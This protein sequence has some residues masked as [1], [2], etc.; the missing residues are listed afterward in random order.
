MKSI[1]KIKNI[2]REGIKGIWKHRSMG[3]AS[4]IST[5]TTLFVIGLILIITITVNNIAYEIQG[6][7]DE[8]EVFI[9]KDASKLDI[10]NL[11]TKIDSIDVEKKVTFRTGKDALDIMKKSWGEDAKLL[12]GITS[13]DL[14]PSS[15][16]V[17]LT[18]I[19][20][21]D[22]FAAQLKGEKAV[23]DI[24]Y[25]KDLIQKVYRISNYIKIFGTA[26]VIVLI[27]VSLFII[28]N[29]IKLTVVSRRDEISVMKYVGATDN[30]VRIPF[31]IEGL[32][33][34]V[35]GALL[36]YFAVYYLYYFAYT[37][38]G[39]AVVQNL[40]IFSLLGPEV[41][42]FSLIQIF[43]S[44]GIGIGVIGSIF[45]IRRYLKS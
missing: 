4:V 37:K 28:S 45:S 35:L 34:G 3:M 31:I 29:T 39:T 25:Y 19:S 41:F 8:V 22:G 24:K 16:V 23:D 30:Y 7:V 1:R 40:S 17:K 2:F 33:F 21:A 10:D 18:D 15:F 42:K 11:C 12:E 36:S 5:F 43:L 32:F 44:I 20:N 27:I 9:K 13:D 14:L 38:L 26:L 6:K